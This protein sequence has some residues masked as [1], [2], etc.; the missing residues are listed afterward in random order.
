MQN[1]VESKGEFV[2]YYRVSTKQQGQSG[3]GL[4][5]QKKAVKDYLNGGRSKLIGEFTEVESGKK[6]DRPQ[7]KEAIKLCKKKGATLV[8]AKLDRLARNVH[9]ISGLME[10]RRLSFL[11]V[12][13]P[14][15]IPLNMHMLAAFAEHE[16][17]AISDRTREGLERAKARGVKLGRQG[18]V[19]A[20]VNAAKAKTQARDLK[21]VITEIRK[22]G[23][24]SVREIM[25]ELNTRGIQTSRGG[26]WRPMTVSR[27][28]ERIDRRSAK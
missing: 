6:V 4:E 2:A 9:F 1:N 5:A 18:K 24:D 27:L 21:P 8:I 22:A 10:D 12:D 28:L 13:N 19:L 11:A 14:L 15:A 23:R 20:R 16:A 3:L 25:A 17:R 26:P 7:L